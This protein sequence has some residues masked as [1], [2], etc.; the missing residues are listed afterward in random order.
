MDRAIGKTRTHKNTGQNTA[1]CWAPA[2]PTWSVDDEERE[3]L[4]RPPV[5]LGLVPA[6]VERGHVVAD[7]EAEVGHRHQDGQLVA[8]HQQPHQPSLQTSIIYHNIV[9]W[10]WWWVA[11][12]GTDLEHVGG[13]EGEK[14]DDEGE[15]QAHVLHAATADTVLSS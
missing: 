15:H 5:G 1:G 11:S 7:G 12:V 8:G 13:E 2:R 14:D 6:R 9:L 10:S 3:E 4:I